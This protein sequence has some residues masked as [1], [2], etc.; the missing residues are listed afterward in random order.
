MSAFAC[1]PVAFH[2]DLAFYSNHFAVELRFG[3]SVWSGGLTS[4]HTGP[5]LGWLRGPGCG[6]IRSDHAGVACDRGLA[7]LVCVQ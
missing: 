5:P 4:G 3:P 6:A 2:N 7:A 1:A